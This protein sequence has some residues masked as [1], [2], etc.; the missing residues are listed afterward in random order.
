M[1]LRTLTCRSI[2][3]WCLLE[4]REDY[5]KN[6]PTFGT[7]WKLLHRQGK[8]PPPKKRSHRR[9]RDG[10]KVALYG[11]R[12]CTYFYWRQL[13]VLWYCWLEGTAPRSQQRSWVSGPLFVVSFISCTRCRDVWG[14]IWF[15]WS[16]LGMSRRHHPPHDHGPP[17]V[18]S[19]ASGVLQPRMQQW[20][21]RTE[22]IEL[23]TVW[24]GLVGATGLSKFK[25]AILQE[26]SVLRE[27]LDGGSSMWIHWFCLSGRPRQ[28]LLYRNGQEIQRIPKPPRLDHVPHI[29]KS[30]L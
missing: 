23:H 16:L 25:W 20:T 14:V 7:L 21:E 6:C 13:L 19:G 1:T 22:V 17:P 2:N 26:V 12:A 27:S 9:H 4:L 15:I 3:G 5:F 28:S 29:V 11:P 24:L 18:L 30:F 8:S 10:S